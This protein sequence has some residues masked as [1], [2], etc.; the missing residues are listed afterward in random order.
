LSEIGHK[1]VDIFQSDAHPDA[2]IRDAGGIELF[3]RLLAVSGAAGVNY[4][5]LGFA[6]VRYVPGQLDG[7]DEP[8]GRVLPTLDAEIE[9]RAISVGRYFC[10]N[11][12]DTDEGNPG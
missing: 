11:L 5:R 1:V 9:D 8:A 12:W 6:D 7:F 3:T 10:A 2:V 4:Q